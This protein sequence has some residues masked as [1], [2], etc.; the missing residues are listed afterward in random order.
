MHVSTWMQKNGY[1]AVNNEKTV[2]M[3]S[4]GNKYIVYGLFV[5]D[6]KHIYS[7]YAMNDEFLALFKK[8]FH[9]KG[10][11]KMETFLGMAVEQS[12]KSIKI[13]LDNNVKNV[14]AEYAD[15]I[16]RALCYKKVQIFQV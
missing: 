15:Y 16:K 2:F 10:G 11:S 8:D 9:F 14:V 7:C 6:M 4:K 5:D 12:D 13:Y 1:S 3:N